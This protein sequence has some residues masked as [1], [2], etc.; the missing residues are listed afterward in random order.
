MNPLQLLPFAQVGAAGAIASWVVL[1]IIIAAVIGIGLI[2]LR[3]SGVEIPG[4]V[5]QIGWILV[6]AIIGIAAIHLLMSMSY[7]PAF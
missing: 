1:A 7:G 6:V 4:W 3:V 2:V 5:M